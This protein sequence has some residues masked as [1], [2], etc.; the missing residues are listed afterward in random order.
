MRGSAR[1]FLYAAKLKPLG[2]SMSEAVLPTMFLE[3]EQVTQY[4]NGYKQMKII[5]AM[6]KMLKTLKTLSPIL[7]L[8]TIVCCP[9]FLEQAA[10]CNFFGNGV[11]YSQEQ[12]VNQ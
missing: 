11:C 10:V 6:N 4:Q 12:D 2:K 8:Y 7:G 3:S 5:I 1:T 9:P